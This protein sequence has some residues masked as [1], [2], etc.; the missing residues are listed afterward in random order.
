MHNNASEYYRV[1]KLIELAAAWPGVAGTALP[2]IRNANW[3]DPWLVS[4]PASIARPVPR[5]LPA[6]WQ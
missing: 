1:D 4:W 5:W 2:T 3:R 6:V